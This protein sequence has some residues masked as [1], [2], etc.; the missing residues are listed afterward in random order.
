MGL[1]WG[2]ARTTN[3]RQSAAITCG[4]VAAT[5]DLRRLKQLLDVPTLSESA[6]EQPATR[7]QGRTALLGHCSTVTIT[8]AAASA[9]SRTRQN[10][11]I[12]RTTTRLTR[13][14]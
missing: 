6:P 8:I 10:S 12:E 7:A 14:W 9:V 1:A 3:S 13:W 4:S 2:Q 5:A 11:A